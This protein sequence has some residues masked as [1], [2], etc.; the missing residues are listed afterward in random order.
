MLQV[1]NQI[2]GSPSNRVNITAKVRLPLLL[3]PGPHSLET[4]PRLISSAHSGLLEDTLSP[5]H[6]PVAQSSPSAFALGSRSNARFLPSASPSSPS[7][8]AFRLSASAPGSSRSSASRML[9]SR[10]SCS[11]S[12]TSL[13]GLSWA[14][15]CRRR[16]RSRGRDHHLIETRDTQLLSSIMTVVLVACCRVGRSVSRRGMFSGK[17]GGRENPID[18]H[19]PR[20]EVE[21]QLQ[22]MQSLESRRAV[23]LPSGP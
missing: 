7:T 1:E 12:S 19:S 22:E 14:S 6:R 15:I 10:R 18:P 11:A 17:G 21:G 2:L 23:C 5:N 4:D 16:R 8:P 13:R 9:G 3:C 20:G